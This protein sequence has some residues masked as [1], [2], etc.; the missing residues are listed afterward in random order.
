[1]CREH[2][3]PLDRYV[4]ITVARPI[5]IEMGTAAAADQSLDYRQRVGQKGSARL[6]EIVA[7]HIIVIAECR[8]DRSVRE[9]PFEL[10]R[11]KQHRPVHKY[12]IGCIGVHCRR[13]I[14]GASKVVCKEI[15][16]EN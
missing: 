9:S 10:L 12:A 6:Q 14:E 2:S 7:A 15:A 5:L 1:M 3:A 13:G 11:Q 16:R 8:E 4:V